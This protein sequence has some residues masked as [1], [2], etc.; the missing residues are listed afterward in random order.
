MKDYSRD[1][2]AECLKNKGTQVKS[3]TQIDDRFIVVETDDNFGKFK[4]C[5]MEKLNTLSQV[6]DDRDIQILIT[7]GYKYEGLN[8][9]FQHYAYKMLK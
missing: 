4:T 9:E 2:M 7:L 8:S 5:D 1:T 6:S 3:F